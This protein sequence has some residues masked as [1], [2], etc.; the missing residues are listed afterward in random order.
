[1]SSSTVHSDVSEDAFRKFKSHLT[2]MRDAAMKSIPLPDD[3]LENVLKQTPYGFSEREVENIWFFKEKFGERAFQD[4]MWT[5]S[6]PLYMN[7]GTRYAKPLRGYQSWL[8]EITE[9]FIDLLKLTPG[10]PPIVIPLQKIVKSFL[11]ELN[12]PRSTYSDESFR[13]N[14]RVI[15]DTFLYSEYRDTVHQELLGHMSSDMTHVI[16]NGFSNVQ[17][18]VQNFLNNVVDILITFLEKN[19]TQALRDFIMTP[20]MNMDGLCDVRMNI[21]ATFQYKILPL[22]EMLFQ[23]NKN[24]ENTEFFEN[25]DLNKWMKYQKA[26]RPFIIAAIKKQDPN[27]YK[28]WRDDWEDWDGEIFSHSDEV[29]SDRAKH[30]QQAQAKGAA[31]KGGRKKVRSLR[32]KHSNKKR[33]HKKRTNKRQ[34]NKKRK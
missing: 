30:A 13:E 15:I 10:L 18:Q 14:C 5:L 19:R 24:Q 21:Q 9:Q 1:M 33:T 20:G 34:T 2:D 8:L 27:Y 26:E 12:T 11:P 31:A 29:D 7:A 16:E 3:V 28:D 17:K 25:I 23:F 6:T 22:F 4:L 32:K